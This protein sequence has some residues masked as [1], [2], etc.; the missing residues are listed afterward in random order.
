MSE[1]QEILNILYSHNLIILLLVSHA[2]LFYIGLSISDSDK[3]ISSLLSWYLNLDISMKNLNF[4]SDN[5]RNNLINDFLLFGMSYLAG[6]DAFNFTTM[7]LQKYRSSPRYHNRKNCSESLSKIELNL[8]LC[9]QQL[10]EIKHRRD[11]FH[12]IKKA[13]VRFVIRKKEI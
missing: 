9:F 6:S 11:F 10:K 7:D 12:L 2:F 3:V 8:R 13:F 1:I 4:L 5:D